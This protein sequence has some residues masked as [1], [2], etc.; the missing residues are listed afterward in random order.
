MSHPNNV[1][2]AS[3]RSLPPPPP[4][5]HQHVSFDAT[6]NRRGSRESADLATGQNNDNNDQYQTQDEIEEEYNNALAAFR[7][8]RVDCGQCPICGVQLFK[9]EYIKKKNKGKLKLAFTRRSNDENNDGI[10]D[11]PI[12][13]MVP[14]DVEGCVK[15]GQCLRCANREGDDAIMATAQTIGSNRNLNA[16]N[17]T[18]SSRFGLRRGSGSIGSIMGGSVRT[19]VAQPDVGGD[20]IDRPVAAVSPCPPRSGS[21]QTLQ[22]RYHRHDSDCSQEEERHL[23]RQRG[24]DDGDEE[25][26]KDEQLA[27]P[28]GMDPNIFHSLPLELQTE[29]IADYDAEQQLLRT[30][31]QPPPRPPPPTDLLSQTNDHISTQV[32]ATLVPNNHNNISTSQQQQQVDERYNQPYMHCIYEGSYNEHHERHG[33]GVLKWQNGDVYKGTFWENKRQGHGSLTFADGTEYVG[34]WE[35][36]LF[37]GEGTRRFANGDVYTGHY[38]YGKRSGPGRCYFANGD[39]YV[40][41]FRNDMI[42][43]FGRYYY[44]NGQ[45]YEGNFYQGKRHGRGKYQYNDGRVE[46]FRYD[47]DSRVGE[48]VRWSKDRKKTWKLKENGKVKGR[49][50]IDEAVAVAEQC[51]PLRGRL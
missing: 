36:D 11:T 26:E 18:S 9:K 37:H 8:M 32:I 7:E 10:D 15:R 20:S 14:L 51:G 3:L 1:P 33:N 42:S 34:M 48:G 4:M 2:V 45:R 49:I 46:I 31:T 21:G 44:N 13:I 39:M 12:P 40:G 17:E 22:R 27:C 24:E 43:G 35:D 19:V 23:L 38:A 47:A 25:E 5:P 6:H 41:E 29:L 28:E 30:T 50:S 16:N